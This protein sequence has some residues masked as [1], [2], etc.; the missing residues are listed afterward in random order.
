MTDQATIGNIVS[1]ISDTNT[2]N[3]ESGFDKFAAGVD[4]AR[5]GVEGLSHYLT[6]LEKLVP[7]AGI[8]ALSA[9]ISVDIKNIRD[10]KYTLTQP[11]K[12]TIISDALT[13]VELLVVA[14]MGTAVATAYAPI[15]GAIAIG[16]ATSALYYELDPD[17]QV[18]KLVSDKLS[19][20]F[21]H[22]DS[23]SAQ[24]SLDMTTEY[25]KLN[26]EMNFSSK[27]DVLLDNPDIADK[28]M[29]GQEVSITNNMLN[30]YGLDANSFG[31]L[32]ISIN[33]N[34][35]HGNIDLSSGRVD[36]GI[37]LSSN[38]MA[39]YD[40]LILDLDG[41]GVETSGVDSKVLFDH[42]ADGTKNATGWVGKDDG[43]LVR[44]IN[45]N[46]SIDTGRELFG[47]NTVLSNGQ[48]AKNAYEA[49]A[50]LDSNKDGVLNNQDAKYSELK[51]WQDA[52]QDGIS[53]AD[54]LKTLDQAGIASI[55]V[56]A[57]NSTVTTLANG[58]IQA[59]SSTYTKTDGTVRATAGINFVGDEFVREFTGKVD[60]S[61]VASLPDMHASGSVRDLR[62]AA[63]LS[64]DLATKL[65]TYANNSNNRTTADLDALVKSWANTSSMQTLASGLKPGG[66]PVGGRGTNLTQDEIYKLN[67]IEKFTGYYGGVANFKDPAADLPNGRYSGTFL[68]IQMD[69][70]AINKKY[71]QLLQSVDTSIAIQTNFKDSMNDVLFKF[72]NAGVTVDFSNLYAGVKLTNLCA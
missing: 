12:L 28:L 62:E 17:F 35:K 42:A 9:S 72:N 40:P 60:T 48:K 1:T 70:A 59:A 47:D 51:I 44:D 25:Y 16:L 6:A 52:N 13:T 34:Y 49:L 43:L 24:K 71:D 19:S 66:H 68:G 57:T 11:D 46:G 45:N 67:V 38:G 26:K 31:D 29:L 2:F 58:N 69:A 8:A 50:D 14:G 32:L 61:Q 33:D 55:K 21:S 3:N 39:V 37:I 30:K 54:E 41:D 53:Q 5:M 18:E 64:T 63:A 56:A 7:G 10:Q 22:I 65:Q 20:I 36:A 15:V 27:Y 23:D 4:A